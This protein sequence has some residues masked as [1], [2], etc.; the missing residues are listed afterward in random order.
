MNRLA[1]WLLFFSLNAWA[2][3]S[4]LSVLP[5]LAQADDAEDEE[6]FEDDEEGDDDEDADD[7]EGDEAEDAEA[8]RGPIVGP[9]R[10]V[11]YL[12][13]D[14]DTLWDLSDRFLANPWYWKKIW[15][16]NPFIENPHWIYPG[17]KLAFV[18]VGEDGAEVRPATAA[19]IARAEK[20]GLNEEGEAVL[21]DDDEDE[22]DEGGDDEIFEDSADAPTRRKGTTKRV[23][24]FDY[25]DP[26]LGFKRSQLVGKAPSAVRAIKR[27]GEL[28]LR[29]SH[30]LIPA[31]D[32]PETG[33]VVGSHE[34]HLLFANHQE[35]QVRFNDPEELPLAGTRLGVFRKT[36]ALR[37]PANGEILG[38]VAQRVAAFDVFE[39]D[40]EGNALGKIDKALDGVER[41]DLVG[42]YNDVPIN[43]LPN[44][45]NTADADG[46]VIGGMVQTLTHFGEY[47]VVFVDLG[48]EDEL[49]VGNSLLVE[50]AKDPV[51]GTNLP[52]PVMVGELRVLSVQKKAAVA[53]VLFSTRTILP[54]DKVIMLGPEEE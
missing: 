33:R 31:E 34:D 2:Q 22:A 5:L 43:R 4:T 36:R 52:L 53:L 10:T 21:E 29:L 27:R 3:P 47:H 18:A 26:Y 38:V 54:G 41:G 13:K 19:E 49:A 45:A 32:A 40:G 35:V 25:M 20:K 48:E 46:R 42:P 14:G 51:E 15:A 8:R 1:F 6:E 11:V 17:Q 39:T 37:D 7:E 23:D 30:F 44:V 12:V 24:L 16:A 50:R 28:N 9:R